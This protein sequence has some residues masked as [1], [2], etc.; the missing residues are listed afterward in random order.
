M[1]ML[2]KAVAELKGIRIEEEFEPSINLRLN[3][4]IPEEYIEDITLRLSL[5][6]K[7]ASAKTEEGVREIESEMEDRFGRPPDEVKNLMDIVRLKIM[8]RGLRVTKIR[9]IQGR[10]DVLFS[11]DT[12][13]EPKDILALGKNTGRKMRFLPEGFELD[14]KGLPWREVYERIASVFTC[15]NISDSFKEVKK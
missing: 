9:D 3:A 15:L 10:I 12:K 7:I 4:F 6:R 14:L 1:E 2:E 11:P 5:Y 13:V 8:A